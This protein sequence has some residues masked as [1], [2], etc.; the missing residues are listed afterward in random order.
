[1]RKD[2][3][4]TE[5]AVRQL[6]AETDRCAREKDLE[7]FMRLGLGDAVLLMPDAPPIAGAEGTRAFYS[8]FYAAF[9]IDM[10]HHLAD[11]QE[12]GDVV[13]AWGNATGSMRPV[14]GGGAMNFDNKFLFVLKRD[15][16]GALKVWRVAFNANAAPASGQ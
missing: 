10:T 15:G 12:A 13:V 3:M 11:A 4:T 7:A 2:S 5:D 14:A 8:G 1:M 16:G 6:F 9:D